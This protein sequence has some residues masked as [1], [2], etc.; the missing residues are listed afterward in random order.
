MTAT[1][2]RTDRVNGDMEQRIVEAARYCFRRYGVDGTKMDDVAR[3]VGIARPNL[4]RYVQSK[5]SLLALVVMVE[6]I[7]TD[8]IRRR[9]IPIEG[10]VGPLISE[11]LALGVELAREDDFL[12]TLTSNANAA[13][14]AALVTKPGASLPRREYWFPIFEHGRTRGELRDDLDNT[15]I[16]RWL[17]LMTMLF[18]ERHELFSDAQSVRRYAERFVV[19]A[20]VKL[21]M[22]ADQGAR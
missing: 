19:P 6:T 1:R 14:A 18:M 16:L 22:H 2:D 15:E 21:P 13:I 17:G 11:S 20:L 8:E 4:Y 3:V 7:K 12:R 10:P 5:D 9:V